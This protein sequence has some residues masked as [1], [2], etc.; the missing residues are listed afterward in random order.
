[1]ARERR[2]VTSVHARAPT[3]IDWAGGWTD[4]P[5]YAE[6]KGGAVLNAAIDL[7]V[8]V[9]FVL[10]ED[11]IRLRAEDLD[12]RVTLDSSGAITY[13][14]KLDLHKA[15]LN[16]FPVTGGI[17]ILSR[18]DAP[19]GSG[20]GASGALDVALVAGLARCREETY[21]AAELAEVGFTLEAV[22]LKLAGGRQDQYA[23]ALGGFHSYRFGDATVE[24]RRLD[25]SDAAAADLARHMVLAY[26]GRSH[27]SSATHDRVWARYT[28]NEREVTDALDTLSQLPERAAAAVEQQ[29]WRELANVI[30]ENWRQQQRLDATITTPHIRSLEAASRA[31]GAWGLKATG[32]GAGGC[33]VLLAPPDA[34]AAVV[35]AL[36]AHGARILDVAFAAEGAVVWEGSEDA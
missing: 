13:D 31:A 20:L 26:T 34:R 29:D 4:V 32:A 2:A 23:A 1:M 35:A 21:D 5:L 3:R 22:E 6:A 36:E 24:A 25:V 30:D 28:A 18:S 27:F 16:M 15:A 10:G 8:H 11:K 9:D 33:V 19:A 14:G 7:Y 12:E 17:E